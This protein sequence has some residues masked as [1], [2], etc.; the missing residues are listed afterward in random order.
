G[1]GNGSPIGADDLIRGKLVKAVGTLL[2]NPWEPVTI[3]GVD[4]TVR[5]TFEREVFHLR[6]AKVLEPEIDA[7]APLRVRLTLQPFQGKL[8]TRDIE[9][10]VPAELA[11]REIDVDLAPGYEVERPL[12]TPDSVAELMANLPNASFDPESIVATFRLR[13]A[14]A[15]YHGKIVSRLPPAA[16]DM[17]PPSSAS[18]APEIFAAQ[19][20]TAVPIK[21]FIVGHD[22]VRVYVRPVLR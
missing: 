1:A 20:H 3:E 2:N 12:P 22:S 11:G 18:D 15:A 9:V 19:V 8:E 13:D 7:G 6:G 17:L 21:R 14:A 5:V 4:T 10:K 16:M